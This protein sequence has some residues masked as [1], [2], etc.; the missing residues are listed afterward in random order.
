MR[1]TVIGAV[2]VLQMALPAQQTP[3]P[4]FDVVSLKHVGD[5]QSNAVQTGP[6]SFLSNMRPFR[7]TASTVS[8]RTMLMTILT[9]A[10]DVKTWQVQG[11]EWLGA[12]VYELAANMPEGTSRETARLML[13]SMLADRMGLKVR[14]DQ[15]EFSVLSL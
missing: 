9:E 1:D 10:Y 15:K 14:R 12:E 7:F 2:L 4:A 3:R 13:Q 5:T 6:G 11:P 8:C